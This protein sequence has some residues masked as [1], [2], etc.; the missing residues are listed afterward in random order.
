MEPVHQLAGDALAGLQEIP[1]PPPVSYVPQTIGWAIVGALLVAALI[2]MSWRMFRRYRANA[3]R[4]AAL[5]ELAVIE[6]AL[7]HVEA[8]SLIEAAPSLP[9]PVNGGGIKEKRR[10]DGRGTSN[11]ASS[12]SP[13]LAKRGEDG[14]GASSSNA[15]SSSSPP[16]A[17]RGEDGRVA[18]SALPAL[19]KW[20][21]IAA[22]SRAKVATLSGDEWLRFLDRSLGGHEFERGSGRLLSRIAYSNAATPEISREQIDSLITLSR[23]WIERHNADV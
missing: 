7:L 17:G 9:S 16:P 15:A 13:P 6:G 14:R 3:Y 10:E 21:A 8:V 2:Y 11:A 20:T 22:T 12:L 23:R 19:L 1:L 5:A 18:L 4:R